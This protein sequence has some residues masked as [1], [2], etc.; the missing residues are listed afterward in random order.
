MLAAIKK[1]LTLTYPILTLLI[2]GKKYFNQKEGKW[3]S[4]KNYYVNG[5]AYGGLIG[6]PGAFMKY[7]QELMKCK[8]SLISEE[9]RALL[10][11][12]VYTNDKKPTGMCLSWFSGELSGH[13]YVSHAGGGGGYYCELRIYPDLAMGSVLFYNRTGIKDERMLDHRDSYY[14]P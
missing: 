8:N 13:K 14:L 9:Y 3:K 12:Q 11:S 7:L 10:F 1:I 2:D 5:A 6:T 4:F